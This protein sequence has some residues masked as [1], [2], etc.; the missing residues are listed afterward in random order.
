[1]KINTTKF[2][3]IENAQVYGLDES[4]IR[5]KYP[6]MIGKPADMSKMHIDTLKEVNNR[7][8]LSSCKTGTGH[9]C[10]LKGIIVQFDLKYT[11]Y[12]T[13]Q[14]QRYNWIDYISSQSQMHKLTH[15][16][17]IKAAVNKWTLEDSIIQ[18]SYL[19]NM[20]ND[21]QL[22]FPIQFDSRVTANNKSDLFHVI[23]SN[24]PMGFE[25]W[26][27]VNT[28]YLQLKTVYQQRETHK[29]NEW[30]EFINFIESLP[31]FKWLVQKN[32]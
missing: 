7:K 31:Y 5:S 17:D 8:N 12:L 11:Q 15:H 25:L 19:I 9:D 22:R 1:M 13:K 4:L 26:T 14:V 28:N 24:C 3:I 16:K 10:F 21:K 6:K 23:I 2:D 20:Y 32:M 29:L 18:L 30:S 27:G